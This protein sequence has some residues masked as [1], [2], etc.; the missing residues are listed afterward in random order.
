MK[1]GVA[2]SVGPGHIGYAGR[3]PTIPVLF[4]RVG[5]PRRLGL[6]SVCFVPIE[7]IFIES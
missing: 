5:G 4:V 1:L 6:G 3:S 2:M 7:D